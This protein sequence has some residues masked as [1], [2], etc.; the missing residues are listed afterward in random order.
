[1]ILARSIAFNVLFYLVTAI[2]AVLGLPFL[3]TRRTALFWAV[4]WARTSV[5]LTRTVAGIRVE[6]RGREKL[7][8]GGCIIASKHQ[9]ALETFAIVPVVSGFAFVLKR[10]LNWIPLFGWYTTRTGMIP[11]NRGG[12]GTVLR[13]LTQVAK[14]AVARGRRIMIYPEGTRRAPGAEPA[15]KFGVIHLY[16]ELGVPCVPMAL[17]TGLFWP[18]RSFLRRPGTAVIEV[19]DPIPPGLPRDVFRSRL[20]TALEGATARLIAE[21]AGSPRLTATTDVPHPARQASPPGSSL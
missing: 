2:M 11:V 12:R 9:S 17:N 15:Y 18:R 16:S 13:A 21:A 20:E 7:P 3:V 14:A 4:L 5:W 8:P 6:V 10:E 1:M 19:L